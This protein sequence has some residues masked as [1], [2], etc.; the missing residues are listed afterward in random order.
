M[1]R[2]NERGA[3]S[4][5]IA[6]ER[7]T[8]RG[9]DD[10]KV[11]AFLLSPR[12]RV[13]R[14]L[15]LQF[16]I[17]LITINVFWY[18]PLRTISFWRRFGGFLAYFV[19]IN[20]IT[21]TSLYVLVPRFLLKDRLGSY[22]LAAI[23]TSLV[24]I[25]SLVFVQGLLFGVIIPGKEQEG[26]AILV[27]SFSG[28][29]TCGFVMAG[30]AAVSV[31]IHWLR[32]NQRIDELESTT[33][34]SELRFLKNQ[35]N[36]HFL[37]NMLNNANVLIKRNP[38]EASSVLFKLEDLLRYQIE[39]SVRERVS[40]ASDIRF[41]NDYLNLEKIRR[42]GF[43]FELEQTGEIESIWI[44]SLLFIPFV[45]NAVKH[46]FDSEHPSRVHISFR[47]NDRLLVFSCSNTKPV[48]TTSEEKVGGIGLANIKR[49]LE[50]L[51]PNNYKLEQEETA[52]K[53]TV[54]L[55]ITL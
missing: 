4:S 51:Y 23:A 5:Q 40:L 49:R 31:F 32:Y 1:S 17:L 14:H 24:M 16:V 20:S 12:Y 47:V 10:D 7:L 19:T 53:Y 41:L 21:Y 33:L 28:I 38:R 54:I 42:D 13:H 46:S 3:Y 30:S 25:V 8:S 35:I 2:K 9:V 44:Q 45:E 43:Q 55:S 29:L 50:L 22:V 15:L 11:T 6:P 27:N 48:V 52:K 36:P 18:E 37:F 39:N 26:I 34:Q